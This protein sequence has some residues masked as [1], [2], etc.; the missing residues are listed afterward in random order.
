[1][2]VHI[3]EQKQTFERFNAQWT[4]TQVVLD[5]EGK[6]RHRM[7]GFL[8]VDDLLAQLELGLAK[9]AFQH[10]AFG[11]AEKRFRSLGENHQATAAA[12]EACYWA[13]VA[14]YKARNDVTALNATA[15]LLKEKYPASEWARKASV[16][17]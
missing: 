4:P 10:K 3:K 11:D 15:K 6:E 8:P 2:K 16:W 9:I 7:E 17:L 12:P 5:P 1:V 13:G 14:A